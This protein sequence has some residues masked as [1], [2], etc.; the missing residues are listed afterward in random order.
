MNEENNVFTEETVSPETMEYPVEDYV[1]G[2]FE[3]DEEAVTGDSVP[4]PVEEM[5][6]VSEAEP[7]PEISAAPEEN[8]AGSAPGETISYPVEDMGRGEKSTEAASRDSR[9]KRKFPWGKFLGITA[10]ILLL[11]AAAAY[12]YGVHYYSERFLPGTFIDGV[13]V[14]NLT[15]AEAQA[16]ITERSAAVDSHFAVTGKDGTVE[17]VDLG[18]AALSRRYSGLENVIAAQNKWAFLPEKE[19]SKYPAGAYTV[20]VGDPF[21]F[22]KAVLSMKMADPVI[23]EAP[24]DAFAAFDEATD[25][26]SVVPEQEGTT[27]IP[28]TFVGCIR[29]AL[30][31]GAHSITFT[32]EDPEGVYEKPVIR[33]DNEALCGY[34]SRMNALKEIHAKVDLG[35]GTVMEI[36]TAEI[37]KMMTKDLVT[38]EGAK[39]AAE[40]S[41]A[42]DRDAF[43]N[44]MFR[45][46]GWYSTK[47]PARVRYFMSASGKKELVDNTDYGW[48]M[49]R[50]ATGALLYTMLEEAVR[51][52]VVDPAASEQYPEHQITAVWKQTANSHETA[53]DV[54]NTWAEVDIANQ[55]MYL[56]VD[57]ALVLD[58]P[59]VTGMQ[60]AKG[61]R[62]PTGMFQITFKATNRDLVGY[63]SDGTEAY[64]SRVN[65]WM[66]FNKN[67]G[68]HDATWRGSFGGEIYVYSG[69][70]GC[71]NMPLA[72]AKELYQY[73]YKGMPVI[74]YAGTKE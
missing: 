24:K 70:H 28:E 46:D 42:I 72:K 60:A 31:G 29:A 57:G 50:E 38:P 47:S 64:R 74:V 18:P 19:I 54:G 52:T 20:V 55:K 26:Y 53:N 69:S 7:A 34:V 14:E 59:V 1:P 30:E 56:V 11:G 13:L 44:Y 17:T 33:A 58:S 36:P 73:V 63:N 10:G 39:P 2:A 4:Y 48:E 15:P 62:T 25:T 37:R 41:A 40:V 32:R 43:D 22:E 23:N 65:Y 21:A 5:G 3:A 45:L 35:A 8:A 16:K 9:K 61:R 27:V 67:I 12:G 6:E 68:F 66:P 71:V 49:D 51:K